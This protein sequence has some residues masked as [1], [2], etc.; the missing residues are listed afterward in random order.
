MHEYKK[1]RLWDCRSE[2]NIII[3]VYADSWGIL[4]Q[5]QTTD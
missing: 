3:F 5:C 4:V 1:Q 2:E